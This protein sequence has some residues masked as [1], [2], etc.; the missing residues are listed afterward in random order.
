MQELIIFA[1]D[2]VFLDPLPF[3]YWITL[4]NFKQ[5]V[6]KFYGWIQNDQW[7]TRIEGCEL[8]V[9]EGRAKQ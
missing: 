4:N 9:Q 7:A 5:I 3:L 2:Y 1:I 6:R 8:T